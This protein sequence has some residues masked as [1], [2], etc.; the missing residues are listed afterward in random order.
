[1]APD[2]WA[3]ELNLAG[4]RTGDSKPE[5]YLAGISNTE[6]NNAAEMEWSEYNE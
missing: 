4:N 6:Y 5:S 2:S 3:S 1:M